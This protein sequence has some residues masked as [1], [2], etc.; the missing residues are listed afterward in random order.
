MSGSDERWRVRRVLGLALAVG[1]LAVLPLT[2]S[3]QAASLCPAGSD[4]WIG[5]SGADWDTASDWS[6]GAVPTAST[7]ACL[8]NTTAPG[9]Y[10]VDINDY[11]GNQAVANSITVGGTA[12]NVVTL[13]LV[14]VGGG[15]QVASPLTLTNASAGAGIL[16][17]GAVTLGSTGQGQPGIISVM[18]GT[19]INQ[20]TITSQPFNN[21]GAANTINGGFNNEGTVNVVQ[22]LNGDGPDASSGA[23]N[24]SANETLSFDY[25]SSA[26]S[27]TQTAGTINNL[28]TFMV[29]DGTFIASGGTSTGNVLSLGSDNSGVSINLAGSATD[30]VHAQ[31]GG[32]NLVGDIG[33]GDTLWSSGEPGFTQGQLF[34]QGAYT[35]HGMLEL[36][37]GTDQTESTL[38]AKNGTFTNAGTIVFEITNSGGDGLNG[39][40]LNTG[41]LSMP[42][43]VGGSGQITN[44]GSI[45]LAAGMTLSAASLSQSAPGTLTVG[46][47]AGSSSVQNPLVALTGAA[48]LGGGLSVTT[49]GSQTTPVT[50][51]QAASVSGTFATPQFAGEAYTVGYS[52]KTVTLSP[53]TS[54]TPTPTT[55]TPTTTPAA[56]VS[57]SAVSG[58][59]KSLTVKLA[60]PSGTAACSATTI[61]ATVTERRKAAKGK[62]AKTKVVTVASAKAQLAAGKK[63][64]V[65]L[66]LN[67]A[68]L[69][70]LAGHKHLQVTVTIS[71]GGKVLKRTKTEVSATAPH[72]KK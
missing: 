18:S 64:T 30:S 67:H 28:G 27:F 66:K 51:L 40:L 9:S 34:A 11:G 42:E 17:T 29:K 49:T 72:K 16:S 47:A 60:C 43:S 21:V 45:S 35:N 2:G 36:G 14:G 26:A 22:N 55:P 61:R 38:T 56:K 54:T 44:Q 23:I 39:P 37:S 50:L 13:A 52:A 32:A 24:V 65:T 58:K 57:V 53:G 70:L 71:A 33:A 31:T 48:A 3:A 68:G 69:A 20:G 59:A 1:V 41:T 6:T 4:V 5:P 7:D 15:V 46:V 19:L 25:S 8:D 12:P 63:R 62:K 10:T